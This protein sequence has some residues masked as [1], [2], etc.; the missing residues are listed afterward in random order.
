MHITSIE[1]SKQAIYWRFTQKKSQNF[2][3][4]NTINSPTSL[5]RTASSPETEAPTSL[6]ALIRASSCSS[7]ENRMSTS[8]SSSSSIR[9]ATA[10]A[11]MELGLRF[12]LLQCADLGGGKSS[13]NA[14]ILMGF[15]SLEWENTVNGRIGIEAVNDIFS[16]VC[17]KL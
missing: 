6:D 11:F 8:S 12:V 2:E 9:A 14:E 10:P 1:L 16:F 15:R 4:K 7:D 5:F 13:V 3:T 17:K